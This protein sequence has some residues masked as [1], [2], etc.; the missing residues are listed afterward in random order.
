MGLSQKSSTQSYQTSW[1]NCEI[2]A[3]RCVREYQ[4]TAAESSHQLLRVRFRPSRCHAN[5]A[6]RRTCS[7]DGFVNSLDGQPYDYLVANHLP[8]DARVAERCL[9]IHSGLR[10]WSDLASVVK[11]SQ[12]RVFFT[13]DIDVYDRAR[14]RVAPVVTH[15]PCV[16]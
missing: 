5:N 11:L 2:N 4:K 6:A 10:V 1:A 14:V 3:A 15:Y 12:S 8:R 9:R 13:R 7:E 16:V